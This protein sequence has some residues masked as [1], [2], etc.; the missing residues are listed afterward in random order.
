MQELSTDALATEMFGSSMP[1]TYDLDK[2]TT[3][4]KFDP[5]RVRVFFELDHYL[6]IMT[7]HKF[8]VTETTALTT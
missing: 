6:Q 7:V 5:A 8:H 1:H 2:S 3:H 4:P